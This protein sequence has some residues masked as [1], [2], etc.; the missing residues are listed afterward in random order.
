MALP[1]PLIDLNPP[2]AAIL[3]FA[4]WAQLHVI[5]TI[6]Y[7]SF[8]INTGKAKPNA[9]PAMRET[10]QT[11]FIG[12]VGYSYNNCIE[13]LPVL[14]TIVIVNHVADGAPDIGSLTWY[15]VYARIVQSLAH[16]CGVTEFWVTA[17]FVAFACQLVLLFQMTYRTTFGM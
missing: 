2:L 7:R 13:N 8:L 11:T 14:L 5:I 6:G 12:R 9:F 3:A 1:T 10:S 16:W 4:V 17:R 15:L